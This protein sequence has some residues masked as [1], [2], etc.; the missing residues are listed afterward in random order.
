MPRRVGGSRLDYF[1]HL[2]G[3]SF[4]GEPLDEPGKRPRFDRL[5][6][7]LHEGEVVSEVVDGV[8]AG[9]QDLVR[10]VQ[11]VQVTSTEVGAGVASAGFVERLRIE[12]VAR[13]LDLHV[14][15][16]REEPAVACVA[17]G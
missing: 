3:P 6:Q 11:M 13:V 15:E 16:A 9:A 7:G 1:V 5:A 4:A 2:F 14:A 8:E 10:P 12:P 17:R